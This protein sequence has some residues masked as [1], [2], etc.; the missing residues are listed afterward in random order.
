LGGRSRLASLQLSGK[1]KDKMAMK[2]TILRKFLVPMSLFVFGTA[3]ACAT[4]LCSSVTTLQEALTSDAG[5]GCTV[6]NVVF[7]NFQLSITGNG[8]ITAGELVNPANAAFSIASTGSNSYSVVADFN[9][10]SG[11]IS[12]CTDSNPP[13][14]VVDTASGGQTETIALTYLVTETAPQTTLT[15][16]AGAAQL[17]ILSTGS[18]NGAN[19]SFVKTACSNAAYSNA[20]GAGCTTGNTSV[21]DSTWTEASNGIDAN[22]DLAANEAEKTG[23]KNLPADLT[24]IGVSDTAFI[25]SGDNSIGDGYAAAVGYFENSISATSSIPEPTTFVL[26][27]GALLALGAIRRKKK[28]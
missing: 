22:P 16:I 10:S 4:E 24:S 17:G 5:G 20:Q 7:S 11:L 19:G 21:Q 26:V 8:N 1:F 6:G 23:S 14:A 25:Y 28:V 12:G 27:G 9:C 3:S 18:N 15:G 13:Y 2:L